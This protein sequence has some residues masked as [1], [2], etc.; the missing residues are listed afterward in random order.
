MKKIILLTFLIFLIGAF[1]TW[2]S[3]KEG[4]SVQ[5]YVKE[6]Y[7][8]EEQLIHAYPNNASSQYLSESM[9]LYMG[10]LLLKDDEKEFGRQVEVLK[11]HFLEESNSGLYIRW[12]TKEETDVNAL[13]DDVRII[14]ALQTAAEQ[15]DQTSYRE[16]ADKLTQMIESEQLIDGIYTDFID[17]KTGIPAQRITLS[18]LTPDFF[19]VLENTGPSEKIL[20][21]LNK[22][23]VFFP[24]YYD[25]KTQS[26][27]KSTEVHM[28]DQLLIALNRYSVGQPS[29]AFQKWIIEEWRKEGKLYGHYTR[30]NNNPSVSYE[31]LSV[32]AYAFMYF[33]EIGKTDLAKEVQQQAD[34]LVKQGILKEAHFFDYIHYEMIIAM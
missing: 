7:M 23:E 12:V 19:A 11:E 33:Q 14:H 17:G 34:R 32:Y 21:S 8:D 3:K 29:P 1:A 10:Y 25:L 9:G 4:E 24:E 20:T 18:Y 6:Q 13:I 26:Y 31:S 16:L 2:W 5:H 22:D 15:F 27:M 28:I 30:N